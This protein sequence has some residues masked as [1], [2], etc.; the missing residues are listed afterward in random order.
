M[1]SCINLEKNPEFLVANGVIYRHWALLKCLNVGI[2]EIDSLSVDITKLLLIIT[3][4]SSICVNN[5]T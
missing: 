5:V 1:M 3:S 4:K 2:V